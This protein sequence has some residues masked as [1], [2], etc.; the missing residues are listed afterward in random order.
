MWQL[1]QNGIGIKTDTSPMEQNKN[2]RNIF[3]YW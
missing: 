1:Q 3:I 2:P